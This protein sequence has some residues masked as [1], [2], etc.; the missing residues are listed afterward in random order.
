MADVQLQSEVGVKRG[1]ALLNRG[2]LSLSMFHTPDG[3]RREVGH[4]VGEGAIAV[5]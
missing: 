5:W 4:S 2:C 1:N 3:W